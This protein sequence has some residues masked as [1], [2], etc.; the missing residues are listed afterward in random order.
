MILL[1]GDTQHLVA[2]ASFDR[3][4]GLQLHSQREKK[5]EMEDGL[6]LE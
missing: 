5:M 4:L 1:A 6:Y 3:R 2:V